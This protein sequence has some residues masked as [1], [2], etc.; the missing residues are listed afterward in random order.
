MEQRFTFDGVAA[1]YDAAR[2]DYPEALFNEIAA[3]AGLGEDNAVL[4]IGCGTGQA[5]RRLAA[6]GFQIVALDPGPELIRIARDRL[7]KYSNIEFVNATFEPGRQVQTR[8]SWFS[9][10]NRY[11]GSLRKYGS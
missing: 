4:E 5:T 1:L 10:R 6:R 8:S 11:T 7:A 3:A 9:R 2:P